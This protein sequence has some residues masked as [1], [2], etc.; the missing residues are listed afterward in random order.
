MI[1][2]L[3]MGNTALLYS[4]SWKALYGCVRNEKGELGKEGCFIF[5]FITV[6]FKCL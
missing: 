3:N 1:S 2:H 5:F 4:L 6:L